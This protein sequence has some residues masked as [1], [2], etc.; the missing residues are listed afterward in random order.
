MEKAVFVSLNFIFIIPF[1][2]L[3]DVTGGHQLG[4]VC[5]PKTARLKGDHKDQ[6]GSKS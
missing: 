3:V 6:Q 5:L 4:G 1:R 2:F